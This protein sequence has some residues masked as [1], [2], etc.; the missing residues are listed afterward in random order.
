MISY[1][2]VFSSV[3][4][5]ESSNH[6][7]H[8]EDVQ[9]FTYKVE[10]QFCHGEHEKSRMKEATN[11]WASFISSLNLGNEEMSTKEYVQEIV[12]AKCNMV[13]LVDLARDREAHLGSDLI[14]EPMQ[15]ND[16]DAQLTSIIKLPQ[17]YE[18]VQL[19]SNFI[20]EHPSEFSIVDL[21]N[22][23]SFMDKLNKMSISNINKHHQKTIDFLL[24]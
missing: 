24:L 3:K 12:D 2:V 13:D 21:M 14:E 1:Y 4:K 10:C 15:G 19:L 16:V 7:K 6:T 8:L 17:A 18:Y 23:D 22:M 20:M 11:E 9:D 5:H